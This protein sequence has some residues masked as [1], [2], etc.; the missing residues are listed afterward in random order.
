MN[1]THTQFHLTR[2]V[3][4]PAIRRA[5]ALSFAAAVL[6]FT[7]VS[8]AQW[9]DNFDSYPS[10][11]NIDGLGGWQG[12]DNSHNQAP[13]TSNARSLSSPNS[14]LVSGLATTTSYSDNVHKYSGYTSG[15]WR[16]TANLFVPLNATGDAY[17][18]LL[19]KY[20]DFGPYDWSVELQL[21]ATTGLIT[22]DF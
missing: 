18:I 13:I 10:N 21:N 19:N 14:V 12:W 22:D 4:K 7:S 20:N 1:K 9:S 2:I 6:G 15:L 8:Y 11:V 5:M 16:Y 17:F 3:S